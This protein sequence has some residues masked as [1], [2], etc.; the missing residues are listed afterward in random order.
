MPLYDLGTIVAVLGA[1]GVTQGQISSLTGIWNLHRTCRRITLAWADAGYTGKL[2][3][4]AQ[5]TVHLGVVI[6]RS[7]DAHTFRVLPRRAADPTRLDQQA[8][9]HRPRLRTAARQPRSHGSLGHD[10]PHGPPPHPA[11]HSRPQPI[12][13]TLT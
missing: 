2:T 1:H 9:P 5:A 6:V 4:W 12:N 10:R 8:P 3:L 13:Q 7:C 11:D